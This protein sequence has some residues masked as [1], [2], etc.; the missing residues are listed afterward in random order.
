MV[1]TT[2]LVKITLFRTGF[3]QPNWT[4][5]VHFGPFWPEEAHFGPFRSANHTLAIPDNKGSCA[6]SI[7][8]IDMP[9]VVR[10]VSWPLILLLFCSIRGRL[11]TSQRF[12][13][14]RPR[15]TRS[16]SRR[17][18]ILRNSQRPSARYPPLSRLFLGSLREFWRKV[19]GKFRENCWKIFP[20]SPNATNSRI[21]GT[22]KGK[23]AGTLGPQCRDLV[24]TFRAGCFLKSTVP[25]FSSFSDNQTIFDTEYDRAKV[26]PYNGN[27]PPPAPGSL[28]RSLFPPLLNN[29]ETRERKGY[30]RGTA[31]NFLH[32]F[33][34]SGTPVVQS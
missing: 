19:P 31:R 7:L 4:N 25:A 28:K 23:P 11:G 18:F 24:P 21:S 32:S 6:E 20:E 2:I 13:Q 27:D 34:L 22:G 8:D 30:E 10:W 9:K 14:E 1:Q 16:E 12:Q 5:M 17:A 26:P 29:V 3:Q 15:D 33:P